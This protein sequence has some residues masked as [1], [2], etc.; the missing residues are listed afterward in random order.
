MAFTKEQLEARKKGIG[1]MSFGFL[2]VIH[3]DGRTLDGHIKWLCQCKCGNKKAIAGNELKKGSTISCGCYRRRPNKKNNVS[4]ITWRSMKDR[5]LNPKNKAYLY[6]GGRGIKV[7]E[8]WLSFY[9]FLSDMGEKPV[10]LTLERINTNGNYEPGNCKWATWEEQHNNTRKSR[11]VYFN[12]EK[13]TI[14][15]WEKNL[16]MPKHV[17]YK[18]IFLRGWDI[19]KAFTTP[20]QQHRREINVA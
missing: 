8:R 3:R 4:F 2:T 7:C 12:E 14:R 9:N 13:K 16:G 15:Q 20:I 19:K 1:G 17:L 11:F 10:G 5:C 18:R 6:Y